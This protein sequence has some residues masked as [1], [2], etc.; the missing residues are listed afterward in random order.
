MQFMNNLNIIVIGTGMYVSGRGTDGYGTVLP[1]IIE[2]KRNAGVIGKV[3][4]VGVNGLHS[5]ETEMKA[6]RLFQKTG[7]NLDLEVLPKGTNKD[8][9]AYKSAIKNVKQPACAIIVVPDHLHYC[10]AK[11]CIN[12]GLNI[13]IVKPLAPTVEEGS[14]LIRLARK[15]NIYGAVEFHK[16]WDEANL[17]MRDAVH[18]GKLGE[19]LYLWVEYSQRKSIPTEIFK[20]WTEKT[21][22]LQ[23]LGV[24]YIDIVRFITG[25]TPIRVMAVGQKYWLPTKGLDAY[26]AIQCMIEWQMPNGCKFNQTLLTNWIDPETSSAMSDQKIKMVGTAGRFESDQKERGIRI[27]LDGKGVEQPNP[28]YCKD[29]MNSDGKSE[30]RGYGVDSILTFLNDVVDLGKQLTSVGE[31][32]KKRPS[33]TEALIS[34]AV[35]EAAHKSLDKNSDWQMIEGL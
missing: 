35:L 25:A 30:W 20:A 1:S 14:D 13:L 24:H 32:E 33:F 4:L 27:N 9:E 3:T 23:Y 22:I 16:R 2:W 29:Y 10:V 17:I 28:Y 18:S 15:K 31:L 6:T 7:V 19:L 26:D 8:Q 12:A 21:S 5:R 11:D 34:T